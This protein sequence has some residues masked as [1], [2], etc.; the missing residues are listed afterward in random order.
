MQ[1]HKTSDVMQESVERLHADATPERFAFFFTMYWRTRSPVTVQYF[2]DHMEALDVMDHPSRILYFVDTYDCPS[3][4]LSCQITPENA[5]CES[6][7]KKSIRFSNHMLV[8][9]ADTEDFAQ[10]VPLLQK[11]AH[12]IY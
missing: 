3:L 8:A 10:L 7:R 2:V 5:A 9:Y 4:T 6:A 1:L 11:S 12:C